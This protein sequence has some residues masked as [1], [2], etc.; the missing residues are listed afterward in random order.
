M[1]RT[2]A[3]DRALLMIISPTGTGYINHIAVESAEYLSRGDIASVAV[4]YA[5]RPSVLSL[6]RRGAASRRVRMLID[7]ICTR[8]RE[9]SPSCRPRVVLFGESL[10][11][12]AS[13][14]AFID[15]GTDG[16]TERGIDNALWIGTPFASLWKQQVLHGSGRHIDRGLVGVF[17]HFD[18]VK[19]LSPTERAQ[20]RYYMVTHH[21]DPVAHWGIDLPIHSPPWMD[22]VSTPSR[23]SVAQR[24][25]TPHTFMEALVDLKNASKVVPGLF[26]A[27]GHDYRGDLLHFV[28]EAYRLPADQRQLTRIEAALR[29]QD[30]LRKLWIDAR[31]I[32]HLDVPE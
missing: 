1:D 27:K 20:L 2:G 6:N 12:W 11:A 15:T 18:Q 5:K 30:V 13:Q 4:Q 23:A 10:G 31:D 17:D 8:I 9:R 28:S 3:F 14:D 21:D 26:E 32:V 25:V 7:G 16:L 22:P 19:A 29:R 24:W